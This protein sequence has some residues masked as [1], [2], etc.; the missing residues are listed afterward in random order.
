MRITVTP[1]AAWNPSIQLTDICVAGPNPMMQTC[2]AGSD[3]AFD[4]QVET[5]DFGNASG[6]PRTM[7]LVIDTNSAPT[8]VTTFDM[9]I[10]FITPQLGDVCTTAFALDGG[11]QLAQNLD[12]FV[13]D[14]GNGIGCAPS[15]GLDRVYSATVPP[16][17]RLTATATASTLADGGIAFS[18]SLNIITDAVCT[19]TSTC[20]AGASAA[21]GT[22]NTTVSYDNVGT[23]AQNLFLV[24]DTSST[25]VQGAFDLTTSIA[26]TVLP[27]GDVC[28]NT[29]AA[30]TTSTMLTAQ[31]MSGYVNHYSF[32]TSL[33]SCSLTDGPDRVYA[34]TVPPAFRLRLISNATFPHSV[35]VVDGPAANCLSRSVACVASGQRLSAGSLTTVYDNPGA[36]RTVFVI[37]DRPAMTPSMDTFDLGIDLQMVAANETCATAGTPITTATTLTAQNLA[38]A[39]ND[40]TW[41]GNPR[42]AA[43]GAGSPDLVYA[44]TVPAGNRLT[45][46][47]TG[48]FDPVV[49]VVDGTVCTNTPDQTC[50]VGANLQTGNTEVVTFDNTNPG[51]RTV[52]VVVENANSTGPATFDLAFAFSVAPPP[53]YTK[54][55]VPA[56]CRTLTAAATAVPNTIGDDVESSWA[57][58]PFT[59]NFFGAPVTTF[60]ASSNGYVGFSNLTTGTIGRQFTNASIPN[61]SQPN[62]IAAPF[63]DDLRDATTPTP[64]SVQTETFGTTGSRRWV[65]QWS[66]IGFYPLSVERLTFQVHVVEG[67][68][69]IEFHYCTLDASTGSATRVTG[70]SA[71]VGLESATGNEGVEHSF[72]IAGS[73]STTQAIRFTP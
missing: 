46:T 12:L 2:V 21:P 65:L 54:T 18:P 25:V 34:V 23:T 56:V 28:G 1:N 52:F 63:W 36:T 32:A 4:G 37:V 47:V 60:S 13:N 45:A 72:N 27:P 49:N 73:V 44:V 17:N 51:P 61:N 50:L 11:A 24:V 42:C 41:S 40:Y 10:Q 39:A 58:M 53:P 5:L 59:F 69:V 7:F 14:Y 33:P 19:T 6:S 70:N 38:T 43:P 67:T 71:T 9:T 16:G 57:A 8:A 68:N 20:V 62:G 22:G 55:L 3:S 26:P 29:A 35:S 31:P 64:T 66:Q 15:T 48:I 30:I